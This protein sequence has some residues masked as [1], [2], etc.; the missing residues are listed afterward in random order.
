MRLAARREASAEAVGETAMGDVRVPAVATLLAAMVA[1]V[2]SIVAVWLSGRQQRR[3]QASA[4]AEQRRAQNAQWVDEKMRAARATEFDACVQ[5]DAAVV[6]AINRLQ[7]V[8]D[9]A[10]RPRLRRY[11]LG[12]DWAQ[13]WETKVRDAAEDLALPYSAVM[14]GARPTVQT[15]VEKVMANLDSAVNAITSIPQHVPPAPLAD[16]VLRRW[17][18][19][20][21]AASHE[22]KQ[23][24]VHLASALRYLEGSRPVPIDDRRILA[25]SAT[26]GRR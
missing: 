11:L 20:V 19:R 8:A 22:L 9:L 6:I 15:A 23:S 21:A 13:Q 5:F 25:V 3:L 24:R 7:Q 18:E 1:V 26:A 12:R 2:G 4:F 14:L 17:R 10:G 16:H